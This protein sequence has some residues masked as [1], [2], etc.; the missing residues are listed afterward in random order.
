[1]FDHVERPP[2]AIAGGLGDPQAIRA[3]VPAPNQRGG[4]RDACEIVR[5]DP[6]DPELAQQA[7][8]NL[9]VEPTGP[10]EAV[11]KSPYLL[12]RVAVLSSNG[13]GGNGDT[14]SIFV[15]PHVAA[16]SANS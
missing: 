1:V 12:E 16:G 6:R 11:G 8:G 14:L 15:K 2:V 9:R 10:F 7:T 13:E 5:R 4:N 3:I